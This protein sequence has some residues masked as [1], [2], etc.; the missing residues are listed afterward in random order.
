MHH[1]VSFMNLKVLSQTSVACRE[2]LKAKRGLAAAG[3]SAGLVSAQSRSTACCVS[4]CVEAQPTPTHAMIHYTRTQ[5]YGFNYIFQMRGSLIPRCLPYMLVSAAMTMF[6]ML[7][8]PVFDWDLQL[9]FTHP[10]SMQ[11]FGLVFGYLAIARLTTCYE[12]YWEG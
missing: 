12:R 9:F 7:S 10:Y 3:L 2:G 6:I 4:T 5:W 1:T 11:L 8:P